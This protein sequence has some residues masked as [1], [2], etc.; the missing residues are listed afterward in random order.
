M[1]SL[2]F[3]TKATPAKIKK[4]FIRNYT[5]YSTDTVVDFYIDIEQS[6]IDAMT[7]KVDEHGITELENALNLVSKINTTNMNYYNRHN[8]ISNTNDPNVILREFCEVKL[9]TNE[10]RRQYQMGVLKTDIEGLAV[11][12]RFIQDFISGKI[13]IASKKMAEIEAQ[14]TA[15]KYPVSE[16]EGDY[17]YLLRMPIYNLTEEKIE[18]FA[19]KMKDMEY[20]F[21]ELEATNGS[22][23]WK[24]DLN[25]FS[26]KKVKFIKKK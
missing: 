7:A 11:K 20:E 15:L 10:K 21:A 1:E 4:Q 25:R 18:E 22:D 9:E 24:E 16:R 14:L 13:Q 12:I 6:R 17:M 8:V 2:I 26:P 3:D 23:M 19:E 5:S